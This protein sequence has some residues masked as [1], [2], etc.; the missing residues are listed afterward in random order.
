M[1]EKWPISPVCRLPIPEVLVVAVGVDDDIGSQ[2]QA[3][4]EAGFEGESK[5]AV[6]RE[7]HD[8]FGPVLT[9]DGGRA[10]GRSVIDDENLD[11]VYTV[12]LTRDVCQR[13]RQSL[14]LVQAR[15]LYDQLHGRGGTSLSSL[16]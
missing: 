8:V 5:A 4:V 11:R 13:C 16:I 3:G 1:G 14:L 15:D 2:L 10:V 12:D 9:G 6:L 7:L